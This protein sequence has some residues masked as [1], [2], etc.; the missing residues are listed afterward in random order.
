MHACVECTTMR[1]KDGNWECSA[2]GVVGGTGG[3]SH[4]AKCPSL[5]QKGEL[6]LYNCCIECTLNQFGDSPPY[7]SIKMQMERQP[8]S[9]LPA[10]SMNKRWRCFR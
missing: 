2:C 8:L 1:N 7:N 10:L 9:L 3:L 5:D 4:C 6:P